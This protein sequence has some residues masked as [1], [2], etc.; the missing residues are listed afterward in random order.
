MVVRFSYKCLLI[1]SFQPKLQELSSSTRKEFSEFPPHPSKPSFLVGENVPPFPPKP[2]RHTLGWKTSGRPQLPFLTEPSQWGPK[3]VVGLDPAT[4]WDNRGKRC[5][6]FIF[7]SWVLWYPIGQGRP[8]T[9]HFYYLGLS[10]SLSVLFLFFF[11][12]FCLYPHP[13]P[14]RV[15]LLTRLFLKSEILL[16][17]SQDCWD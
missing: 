17:L 13:H 11:L 6:V 9:L 5:R 16:P 1:E 8:F 4:G 15:S 10:I 3:W 12:L 2:L 14:S 7:T